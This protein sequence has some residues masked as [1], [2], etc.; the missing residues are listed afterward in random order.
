MRRSAPGIVV[1]GLLGGLAAAPLAGGA[2][3]A[4]SL[5]AGVFLY[6]MPD[7]PD[8][9]FTNSV[10]LLIEHGEKGSIGVVV[11]RP[12][13]GTLDA[14]LDLRE[15]TTRVDLPL[16]WGGPV[17]PEIVLALLRTPR[18]GTRA[19]T[20]ID[21][22]QI[23]QDLD[24]VRMALADR[25]PLV[26]VRVFSGYAGWGPGQL[27]SEMRGGSWVVDAADAATVFSSEPSRLWRKVYEILSRLQARAL[28]HGIA[29]APFPHEPVPGA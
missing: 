10:I 3:P 14:V 1:C 17:Q 6:A 25:D 2:D 23:T 27:A 24:A 26:R 11:N 20:V 28:P 9:N 15:G 5:K 8:P 21:G 29:G 16:Y 4:A 18:P 13:D 19:R 7:L 12:L 22:V